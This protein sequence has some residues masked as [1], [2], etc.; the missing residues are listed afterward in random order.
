MKHW[1]LIVITLV[2]AIPAFL[3]GPIIWPPS[4]DIQPTSAQLPL[5]IVLAIINALVLGIGILFI[6]RAWKGF[7]SAN[8]GITPRRELLTF[9]AIAWLLVSWWPHDNFHIS[10]G[11]NPAGL[12]GIEYGF[13]VTLIIASLI[14]ASYFLSVLKR[15]S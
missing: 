6:V 4:S 11:L 5:F 10:N 12:L 14:A 3:L 9:L 1:R 13:H 8:P 15:K 2:I 7:R